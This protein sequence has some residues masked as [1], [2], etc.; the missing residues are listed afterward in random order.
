MTTTMTT[1]TTTTATMTTA[2]AEAALAALAEKGVAL[3]AAWKRQ[4]NLI[5][6]DYRREV[7]RKIL[8]EAAA[9]LV[10]WSAGLAS[11]LLPPASLPLCAIMSALGTGLLANL[12]GRMEKTAA[13]A[14]N[15]LREAFAKARREA[16][17][18]RQERAVALAGEIL[19]SGGT[20]DE[21]ALSVLAALPPRL[22]EG[23]PAELAGAVSSQRN[24]IRLAAGENRTAFLPEEERPPVFR[25]PPVPETTE[26]RWSAAG[27]LAR[28]AALPL[29]VFI[30]TGRAA[31]LAL[32]QPD[33]DEDVPPL[34]RAEIPAPAANRA[35]PSP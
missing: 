15:S 2:A 34:P 16:F 25:D 4:A 11:A 30:D 17:E 9:V 13:G 19:A 27:T 32:A 28:L 1:T 3:P 12:A 7:C 20:L 33:G 14:R 31:L 29:F 8:P 22:L 24:A 6:A 5:A 21:K 10:L 35:A 26:F 23:A 18:A